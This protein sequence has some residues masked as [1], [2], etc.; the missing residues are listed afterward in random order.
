MHVCI[1]ANFSLYRKLARS[2]NYLFIL[3]PELAP[4]TFLQLDNFH[5]LLYSK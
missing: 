4:S 1:L 3:S 5:L 2:R